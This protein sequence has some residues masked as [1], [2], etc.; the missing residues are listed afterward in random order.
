MFGADSLTCE[1]SLI[2]SADWT[3]QGVGTPARRLNVSLTDRSWSWF[4]HPCVFE[5]ASVGWL[6]HHAIWIRDWQSSQSSWYVETI[7]VFHIRMLTFKMSILQIRRSHAPRDFEYVHDLNTTR[8]R[9][10]L[11]RLT[12]TSSLDKL[13][14]HLC[15]DDVR[16]DNFRNTKTNA[17]LA[18]RDTEYR[19][20]T[21]LSNHWLVD[22]DFT[23]SEYKRSSVCDLL[24]GTFV[25][26]I[27]FEFVDSLRTCRIG[28]RLRDNL[29]LWNFVSLIS[30]A[31]NRFYILA[32]TPDRC[33][34]D[35]KNLPAH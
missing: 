27:L 28:R 33:L 5:R 16:S 22:Y 23:V 11:F 29:A 19:K 10:V 7:H 26:H 14:P 9:S 8:C 6:R 20:S 4:R 15:F 31:R 17:A 1:K 2:A 3:T 24:Y 35:V 34:H 25:S 30:T 13:W 21:S 32:G 12:R 18:D